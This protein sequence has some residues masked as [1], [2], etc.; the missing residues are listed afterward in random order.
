MVQRKNPALLWL[1]AGLLLSLL[2]LLVVFTGLA[3]N[4][5]VT[6]PE[7]IPETADSVLKAVQTGDWKALEGLVSGNPPLVPATGEENTAEKAIWNAYQQSLTW[8]CGEGFEIRGPYV[9][10]QVSVTCLDIARVTHAM[11]EILEDAPADAAALLSAAEKIL[12]SDPPM[13]QREITLTFRRGNGRWQLVPNSALQ[14]LL[15]GFTA[16]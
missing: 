2:T 3:G 4:V 16:S 9:T 13:V 14:A 10:Q 15:S 8:V 12:E 5:L 6:D 11:A 1:G 7:G